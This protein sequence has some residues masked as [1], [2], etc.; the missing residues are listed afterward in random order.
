MASGKKIATIGMFDGVHLGH[1]WL[2]R[3][4]I[5]EAG[6]MGLEP[7]VF[8]FDRH[9]LEVLAPEKAPFYLM[10]L[11]DKVAMVKACGI[12]DVE[13]LT[14]DESLRS[15]A[16][17]Q[18]VAYLSDVYGVS[19]IM[20]GFNHSFGSD[21]LTD[22]NDYLKVGKSLGVEMIKGDEWC[23]SAARV[24]RVC[25]SSIR[26]VLAD[27]DMSGAAEMLGRQYEISGVVVAGKQLG[28]KIGFPTANIS[29]GEPRQLI[30]ASGVY[31]VDVEL[32]SGEQRR[33]MLNIG[34]RPTVDT[35]ADAPVSIEVH[36]IGWS[37]DLYGKTVKIRFVRRLR[38]ERRFPSVEALR[39]QLRLD[40]EE[41]KSE[42]NMPC[43]WESN[44][45]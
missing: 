42:L 24:R 29:P 45:V 25:S 28:R 23:G 31:A 13:V 26:R 43:Q 19:A 41:V 36:I 37:G 21:R 44:G 10:P 39:D 32:D 14:F 15:Q 12:N 3:N 2:L 18:F 5:A 27:G 33:A 1:Q 6:R 4:L 8:T 9:P 34:V 20:M 11:A 17:S 16:A 22:F 35:S 7:V 30:P 40:L 38:D